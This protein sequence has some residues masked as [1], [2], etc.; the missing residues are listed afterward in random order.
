MT[1]RV[2]VVIPSH[3]R[4]APLVRTLRALATQTLPPADYEVIVVLD[5]AQDDSAA[6]VARLELPFA[7]RVETQ[8]PLGAAAARN[9]G[10]AAARAPL[11]LFLDDDMEAAP[12]LLAAHLHAQS[13]RP[14]V[15]LGYFDTPTEEDEGLLALDARLWWAG[16][17]AER[18]RPAHRFTFRDL[19]TGNVSISR[20]HFEGAGGFDEQFGQGT[21]GED[22]EL[23]VRLHARHVPFSFARAAA[24]VHHDRP[25]L[26][27][28]RGRLFASGRG[29]ALMVRANPALFRA[30]SFS[31]P[32]R[33]AIYQPVWHLIW[34]RP[35]LAMR[36]ARP[37]WSL[38]RPLE[39]LKLRSA[40]RRL[41]WLLLDGA[42]WCGVST[43]LGDV[44]V[45]HELASTVPVGPPASREAEIDVAAE[46]DAGLARLDAR[47]AREPAD[48]ARVRYGSTPIGRIA[49]LAGA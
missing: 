33:R 29:H 18:A 3:R 46:L 40:W 6:E 21:A 48:A 25:T 32:P 5:G 1:P 30:F 15:V 47:L 43:E 14:G 34:W 24:S 27:R 42:Y 16:E 44:D 22:W 23:G 8:P 2:S 17:L 12:Q 28:S 11:L 37:L 19:W 13:T 31:S 20:E 49:P 9:R 38:L 39:A 41:H 7:L 26:A 4:R 35:A 10:A 36:L 45:W